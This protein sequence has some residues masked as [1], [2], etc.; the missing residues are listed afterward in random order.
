MREGVCNVIANTRDM[1][2]TK[3]N[4]VLYST[5]IQQTHQSHCVSGTSAAPLP[6]VYN[7]LVITMEEYFVA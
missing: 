2:N 4:V 3:V 7:G 1:N 6:D 5:V